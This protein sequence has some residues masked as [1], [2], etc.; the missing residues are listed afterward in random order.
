[1]VTAFGS[2][3]SHEVYEQLRLDLTPIVCSKCKKTMLELGMAM[4]TGMGK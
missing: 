3:T 2:S 4:G 1:M